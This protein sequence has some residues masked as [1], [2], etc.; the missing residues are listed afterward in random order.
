M[1]YTDILQRIDELVP[2][3]ANLLLKQ[4]KTLSVAE[5]CTGGAIASAL[6]RCAG[7]SQWFAAGCVAY[8]YKTKQTLLGLSPQT[9]PNGSTPALITPETAEGMATQIAQKADT[10]FAI[11]TS[12]VCG[13][14]P[15]EE[16]NPLYVWIAIYNQ[17]HIITELYQRE[18]AGR[19]LNI[20]YTTLHALRLLYQQLR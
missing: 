1:E 20:L 7:A 4:G 2:S 12:G 13:P 10:N 8:T 14:D 3:I 5:S 15:S 18:D 11:A 6:T 16:Y 19:H 17:G 9:A